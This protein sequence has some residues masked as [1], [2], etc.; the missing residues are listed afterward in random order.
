MGG[1]ICTISFIIDSRSHGMLGNEEEGSEMRGVNK[2]MGKHG[3]RWTVC[4][5][6]ST[7]ILCEI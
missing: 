4:H 1:T 2:D 6:Y 3:I 7:S 5:R